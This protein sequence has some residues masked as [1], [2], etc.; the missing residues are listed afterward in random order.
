MILL[1]KEENVKYFVILLNKLI[2]GEN[3]YGADIKSDKAHDCAN[4]VEECP[5]HDI[6]QSLEENAWH[7]LL[8]VFQL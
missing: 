8:S 2:R 4:Q 3:T 5:Y 7:S 6:S 1:N